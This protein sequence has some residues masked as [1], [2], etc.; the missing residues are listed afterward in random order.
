MQTLLFNCPKAID[1]YSDEPVVHCKYF[2]G[3][4]NS[5]FVA[6]SDDDYHSFQRNS[7]YAFSNFQ[8][9]ASFK[10]KDYMRIHFN[11][12]SMFRT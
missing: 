6:Y 1:Y 10:L 11:I 7:C 4:L 9:I 12:L 8:P 5:L 3:K 2:T